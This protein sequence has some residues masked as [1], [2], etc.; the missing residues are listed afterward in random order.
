VPYPLYGSSHTFPDQPILEFELEKGTYRV[1]I[2]TKA[3][4][5][6]PITPLVAGDR[7]HDPLDLEWRWLLVEIEL[8]MADAAGRKRVEM[9][10]PYC[11]GLVRYRWP[12]E[13]QS[14]A[15]LAMFKPE[16][17]DGRPHVR[18]IGFESD[19]LLSL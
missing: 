3:I 14:R 15:A 5:G 9:R 10:V 16:S 4:E 11:P 7:V 1:I 6:S 19:Q 13:G 2:H 8:L 17:L 18:L 12:A